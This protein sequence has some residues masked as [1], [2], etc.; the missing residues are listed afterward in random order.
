MPARHLGLA[1]A[2]FRRRWRASETINIERSTAVDDRER[3]RERL[4][5]ARAMKRT[6][7]WSKR[8]QFDPLMLMR[9]CRWTTARREQLSTPS[10]DSKHEATVR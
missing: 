9:I 2:S 5:R 10:I 3:A 8:E 7:I 4:K 1:I 6:R